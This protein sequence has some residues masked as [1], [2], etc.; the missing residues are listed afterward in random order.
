[1]LQM[2]A[3]AL[4][5]PTSSLARAP[6]FGEPQ[7][8]HGLLKQVFPHGCV[9]GHASDHLGQRLPHQHSFGRRPGEPETIFAVHRFSDGLAA[10]ALTALNSGEIRRRRILIIVG[11]LYLF[12]RA[13]AGHVGASGSYNARK[14]PT[15]QLE[16]VRSSPG[17]APGVLTACAFSDL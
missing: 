2:E 12:F 17:E 3:A 5:V 7:V 16:T 11:T 15:R 14:Y 13:S 1:M 10:P 6:R 8:H 9:N 4:Q